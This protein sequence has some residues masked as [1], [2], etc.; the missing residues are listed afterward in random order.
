MH[1]RV[2]SSLGWVSL[3]MNRSYCAQALLLPLQAPRL[4]T[5]L[6]CSL[7]HMCQVKEC[8]RLRRMAAPWLCSLS[9]CDTSLPRSPSRPNGTLHSLGSFSPW[10]CI[11]QQV[12]ENGSQL[13]DLFGYYSVLSNY[14]VLGCG[15]QLVFD[16]WGVYP[17]KLRPWHCSLGSSYLFPVPTDSKKSEVRPEEEAA[18][19]VA[20]VVYK[21]LD[22]S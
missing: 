13:L 11:N 9:R 12:I 14:S 6:V 18:G 21:W 1:H 8:C 10:C 19:L 15:S 20:E 22:T 3:G 7:H 16:Y 2:E 17:G 5:R 4:L